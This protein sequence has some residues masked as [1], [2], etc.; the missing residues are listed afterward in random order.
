MTADVA[1]RAPPAPD[2]SSNLSA[3]IVFI[4]AD[5]DDPSCS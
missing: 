1:N 3:A 4:R 5:S 2:A